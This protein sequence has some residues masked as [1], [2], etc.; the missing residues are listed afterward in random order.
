MMRSNHLN[1]IPN[2]HVSVTSIERSWKV[3]VLDD[4]DTVKADE[5]NRYF[6]LKNID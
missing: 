1:S 3:V 6:V 4:S 2:H 5:V